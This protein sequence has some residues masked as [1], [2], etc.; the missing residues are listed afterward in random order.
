MTLCPWQL[1]AFCLSNSISLRCLHFSS[2]G[3]FQVWQNREKH[4]MR[5]PQAAPSQVRTHTVPLLC[6][7][8]DPRV[9][10]LGRPGSQAQLGQLQTFLPPASCLFSMWHSLGCCEPLVVFLLKPRVKKH[11]SP[12]GTVSPGPFQ[13]S[14]LG[15]RREFGQHKG[16]SLGLCPVCPC[17]TARL[18]EA[19]S[20]YGLLRL[21]RQIAISQGHET[22][23]LLEARGQ[24]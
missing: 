12:L 7:S 15:P 23:C 6:S 14:Y 3:E 9:L 5:A 11:C 21:A 1:W 22:K 24:V 4:Q 18:S 16:Q 19:G 13:L 17:P 20:P 8:W 10:G 2:L